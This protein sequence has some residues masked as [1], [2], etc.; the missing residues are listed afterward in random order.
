MGMGAWCHGL[1]VLTRL[2]SCNLTIKRFSNVKRAFI[3]PSWYWIRFTGATISMHYIDVIMTTIASQITS[4][5]VVYSTVYSDADQRK[6]QSSA[7]LAFVWGIHRDRWIP[8]TKG[9]LRGKC[10]HLMTSSWIPVDMSWGTRTEPKSQHRAQSARCWDCGPVLVQD[11][12]KH[13]AVNRRV[14]PHRRHI[15]QKGWPL[16]SVIVK[17]ISFYCQWHIA[18]ANL[19]DIHTKFKSNHI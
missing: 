18:V 1:C 7:S 6:H 3:F 8:R 10:F 9:Q 17:Y 2:S 11:C 16:E 15:R 14:L 12:V 4:L 13:R 5:T 19:H